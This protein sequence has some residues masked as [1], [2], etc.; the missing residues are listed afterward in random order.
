M[1]TDPWFLA[2]AVPAVI[3][4]GLSKGGFGGA[5]GFAAV[6]IIALV[7]SPVQAAGLMLPILLVMD[8]VAVWSFCQDF[9]RGLVAKLMPS[10]LFGT[11]L[12]WATAHYVSDDM[13]RLVVGILALAFLARV[14]WLGHRNA[15]DCETGPYATTG[16]AFWGTL[17][18]YASFIAHS[19]GPPFQAY[20]VPLR[21]SPVVYAAT[22]AVFFGILNAV[23]VIPYAA[24]GQ[25]DAE[26]LTAAAAVAPIA[27]VSTWYGVK[28][29]RKLDERL[30]YR[31]LMVSILIVAV[32][33]I[34]DGSAALNFS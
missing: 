34:Y 3:L 23:K 1:I 5:F 27:I 28:L 11:A 13:V 10:A 17:T 20:V 24:L 8:V 32:K 15:S 7:I 4:T 33:L 26:N 6:P 9:D 18:G 19:G 2:A 29:V 25:F 14:W 12:G 31:I 30:F 21:L 22:S 16:A